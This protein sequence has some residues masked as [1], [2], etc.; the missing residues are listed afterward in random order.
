MLAAKCWRSFG[1]MSGGRFTPPL[2]SAEREW[3]P[4]KMSGGHF[5][6]TF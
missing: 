6:G 4:E 2:T 5:T 3:G 1:E